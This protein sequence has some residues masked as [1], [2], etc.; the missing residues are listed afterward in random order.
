M[1]KEKPRTVS[2]PTGTVAVDFEIRVCAEHLYPVGLISG[3][4]REPFVCL[5]KF[6]R[7]EVE[8]TRRLSS[9][10]THML[11]RLMRVGNAG[12]YAPE[13]GARSGNGSKR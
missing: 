10:L 8:A 1:S 7:M 2:P 13:N 11:P 12:A 3:T 4:S 5:L 9:N 6:H